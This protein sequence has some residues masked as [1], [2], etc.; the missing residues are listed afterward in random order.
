MKTVGIGADKNN[1][2]NAEDMKKEITSLKAA[3]T[4]LKNKNEELSKQVEEL[5]DELINLKDASGEDESGDSEA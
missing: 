5:T 2:L 3:N 4:K 1:V